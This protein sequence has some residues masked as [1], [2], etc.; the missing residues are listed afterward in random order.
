MAK[1][2]GLRWTHTTSTSIRRGISPVAIMAQPFT[3]LPRL[4]GRG[5]LTRP[6][7]SMRSRRLALSKE[8]RARLHLSDEMQAYLEERA[9]HHHRSV[10]DEMVNILEESSKMVSQNRPCIIAMG[11]EPG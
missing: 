4:I 6:L 7:R 11:I 9:A 1:S 3:L 10:N 5:R 2:M 8:I